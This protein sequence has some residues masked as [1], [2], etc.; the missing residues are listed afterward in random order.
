MNAKLNFKEQ[1][2]CYYYA[3]LQN[4]KEAAC[5][6]G[7]PK[8]NAERQGDKLLQRKEIISHIKKLTQQQKTTELRQS[9]IAG[10]TRLAFANTNDAIK[11]IFES[12]EELQEHIEQLDLFHIAEIKVKEGSLEIKFFDRFKALQ[13]LTEL[14]QLQTDAQDV[15][16]FY[17]ALE[18]S[19]KS[20]SKD[21]SDD[22]D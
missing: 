10:L 11:L 16:E 13:Q 17:K 5:K 4:V 7:Y 3:K 22:E 6:A 14:L 19:A 20:I 12:K 8:R 15:N 1:M 2:F 9:V 18:F 21:E